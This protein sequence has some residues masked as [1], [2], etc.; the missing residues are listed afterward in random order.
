ML[1][2]YLFWMIAIP[3]VLITGIS[4]S[5]FAGG[6]GIIAVPMLALLV[7][8]LRAAAIM[9][10]LLIFMD[11]LSL[12]YWRAKQRNDILRLLLPAAILG[13]GLGY[14][15]YDVLNPQL[16]KLLLGVM[17]IVFALW[18]LLKGLN[19]AVTSMPWIGRVAG[20]VAGLTSFVAHAGGPPVNFYLL[21]MK[22]SKEDFLATAVYF[23]AAINFI[24]LL[25]YAM[26][27][28]I[29][30]DNLVIALALSPVAWLGVK[31][32]LII[33]RKIS[34]ELFVNLMFVLLLA[35]GIKLTFDGI[36]YY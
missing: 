36:G 28:Q 24:K 29:N 3:A 2:N 34:T 22:L 26:L 27:G 18:G 32:G 11:V 15:L 8:P 5:G 33:Q 10:P 30:T 4:K 19:L 25:P 31:L 1:D 21:P 17:S 20:F 12:R 7:D 14:L 9:L 13:I 6:I 16:I 35:I 23:F